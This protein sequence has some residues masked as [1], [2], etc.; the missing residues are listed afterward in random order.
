MRKRG[1]E[2]R[3]EKAR[4]GEGER[5]R[6]RHG[7]EGRKK[8]QSRNAQTSPVSRKSTP[9]LT[10]VLPS[11]P[12]APRRL[13]SEAKLATSASMS[14]MVEGKKVCVFLSLFSKIGENLS[15]IHI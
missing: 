8:H 2:G 10:V 4:E 14:S 15:L 5:E 9:Y 3:G 13:I 1:R 12:R 7:E 11:G 6:D